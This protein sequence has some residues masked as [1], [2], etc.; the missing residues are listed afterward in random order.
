MCVQQLDWNNIWKQQLLTLRRSAALQ[1]KFWDNLANIKGIDGLSTLTETQLEKMKLNLGDTLLE[2]G[3]GYG[4]LT[5]PLAKIV[6]AITVVEPSIK[7]L[8]ILRKNARA[9]NINN[10]S[11]INK[12]W[13]DVEIDRDMAKHD[14][15]LASFSLL[16]VD[17][18]A[19]LEKMDLAATRA[20]YVFL[21]ADK[22][23][24]DELQQLIFGETF[25]ILS[26]HII[27]YNLLHSMDITA[28]IE[29]M[30]YEF[31]KCFATF[32][33]AVNEFVE[34]YAVPTS[35]ISLL[36]DY[37]KNMLVKDSIGFW[38]KRRRKAAM[39]WWVK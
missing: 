2:I 32:K 5:I 20:V 15:V 21:S 10:I 16:L 38:Y 37:L 33:E 24:P 19:A 22:W 1:T 12:R 17:L 30:E 14:I 18:K 34:T 7:M 28:N 25:T 31:K 26:D 35:K 11:Y 39:I 27:V 9:Q 3:P 23:I 13:E 6:K 4:R 29:V 36:K 8:M